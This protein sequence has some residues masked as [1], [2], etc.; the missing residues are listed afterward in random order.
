MASGRSVWGASLLAL[1]MASAALADNA[2]TPAQTRAGGTEAAA[3]AG[4]VRP[5]DIKAEIDTP[6]PVTYGDRILISV[7][8]TPHADSSITDVYMYPKGSIND[9]YTPDNT[10]PLAR[11]K[12]ASSAREAKRGAAPSTKCIFS[13]DDVKPGVPFL[14]RCS[15]APLPLRESLYRM[16]F[17]P[18]ARQKVELVI[19]VPE[20]P[21]SDD[22]DAA[23][24]NVHYYETV[25]IDFAS[26][27]LTIIFGGFAG[28]LLLSFFMAMSTPVQVP[29]LEGNVTWR[30]LILDILKS[31]PRMTH[32]L[33]Y[34][35]RRTARQALLGSACAL[36]LIV[37]AQS[38]DGFAPPISI[39]IQDFWG[40]LVIGLLSVPL[41]KWLRTKL[42]KAW[43]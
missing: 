13:G 7:W 10:D 25:D 9:I 32:H 22:P 12:D 5:Y 14:V 15:L 30:S 3:G 28:A 6:L 29:R 1:L 17:M 31:T 4:P 2:P 20:Y 40:G 27:K 8:L 24:R 11:A 21:T 16:I 19:I 26:S 18:P 35:F 39:R 36:V 37:T 33:Y 23:T 38:T 42:Q 43:S 34:L 41:A